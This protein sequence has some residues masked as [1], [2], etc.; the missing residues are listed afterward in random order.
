MSLWRHLSRGVR[1]LTKPAAARQDADEEVQHFYD[2][3]IAAWIARGLSPEEARR[4][5]RLELG[6]M[7]VVR[8]E[9]RAYGWENAIG[10]LFGDL[11]YAARRLRRN[12]GFAAVSAVTLALGI[13]AST[14]IFSA[15]NPILFQPLPYPHAGRIVTIWDRANDGSRAD[16]TFGTYREFAAR[17]HAF[18]AIAAFKP[19]Q[20]AI[21]GAAEPERLDGQR[22]AAG[23]FRALGVSPVLGRDFDDSDDRA[24]GPNVVVL[25]DGLWRRRFGAD[26]SIVGRQVRL[27]DNAFTC[28]WWLGSGP[29]SRP[30]TRAARSTR[31]RARR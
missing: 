8:E 25:G 24:N 14:A 22:V 16:V 29:A 12:P 23:Y 7:T 5:A 31:S 9:V 1:G 28:A 4:R 21:A 3:A 27:N 2:E 26:A 11:R 15:V 20:P 19:W 13:G 30:P 10:T 6:N 18:E 17:S